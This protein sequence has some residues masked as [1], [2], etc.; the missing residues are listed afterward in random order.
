MST[1]SPTRPASLPWRDRP[2]REIHLGRVVLW[3]DDFPGRERRALLAQLRG[4]I[5]A[6]AVDSS[7]PAAL[8]SLGAPRALARTYL[9]DL[10]NDRPRWNTGSAPLSAVTC[11]RG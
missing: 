9:D 5:D 11:A 7:M 3:L 6:A 10:P 8:A 4:D 1:T 2:R